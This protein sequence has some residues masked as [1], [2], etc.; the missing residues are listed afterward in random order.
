MTFRE[1]LENEG[2][3]PS[4]V[5]ELYKAFNALHA[6]IAYLDCKNLKLFWS[7][8]IEERLKDFAKSEQVIDITP[9]S[10]SCNI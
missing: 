6:S 3:A 4:R 2:I 5:N 9:N 1:I 10:E 7:K 8:S